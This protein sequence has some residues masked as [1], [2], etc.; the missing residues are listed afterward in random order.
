M[1]PMPVCSR[2]HK[3]LPSNQCM[4]KFLPQLLVLSSML[5]SFHQLP[6]LAHYSL[7]PVRPLPD[8]VRPAL[9]STPFCRFHLRSV[10]GLD[11]L[12]KEVDAQWNGHF[13][14]GP[15]F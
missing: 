10:L 9:L 8:G 5:L 11:A 14:T 6:S 4:L 7:L 1:T 12:D 2:T 15:R 13:V 3:L